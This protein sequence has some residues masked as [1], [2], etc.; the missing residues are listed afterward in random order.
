AAEGVLANDTDVDGDKLTAVLDKG[1]G[2]GELTLN[3]DGSFTYTPDANY[4]G[5]DSFTYKANDGS[6]DNDPVT[7]NLTI[8]PVNDPPVAHDDN[9]AMTQ[10]GALVVDAKAGV[11]AND[12]D[13]DGDQLTATV[14]SGPAH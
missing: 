5:A 13:V 8:N 2:H 11:L 3:A 6:L 12:K 9:Y 4:N 10:G 7:V 1:P 14:A